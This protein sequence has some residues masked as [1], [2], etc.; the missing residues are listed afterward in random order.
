MTSSLDE[1][2]PLLYRA[3]WCDLSV[4]ARIFQRTSKP[5]ERLRS[6]GL[7]DS[8]G[9]SEYR[10][11]IRLA[12]GG[13][14]RVDL[15]DQDGDDYVAGCDGQV[16]WKIVGGVAERLSPIESAPIPFKNLLVPNWLV[17]RFAIDVIG[18]VEIGDRSAYSIHAK[19]RTGAYRHVGSGR[20]FTEVN[21][22][23]DAQ[24]GILLRCE[25]LDDRGARNVSELSDIQEGRSVEEAAEVFTF[26]VGIASPGTGI[27][28]P[29]S[30]AQPVQRKQLS[31]SVTAEE[32]N[33]IYRSHLFPA[34]FSAVLSEQSNPSL[35]IKAAR[36]VL[37]ASSATAFRIINSGWIQNFTKRIPGSSSRIAEVQISM[38]DRYRIDFRDQ[39]RGSIQSIVYD[40]HQTM[41]AYHGRSGFRTARS[42]PSG[43]GLIVDPAWLLDCY[44]LSGEGPETFSGRA[45]MRFI[46]VAENAAGEI[47]EGPLSDHDVPA[48]RIEVTIDRELG[49]TLRLAA[50]FQ[51]QSALT[52][53]LSEIVPHVPADA[54]RLEPPG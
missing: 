48:D 38:P 50:Y 13:R 18:T 45:A 2:I 10:G 17:A 21:G 7:R 47:L 43:M 49:I 32:L 15:T 20:D 28:S 29:A 51:G 52:C 41:K 14:Y 22:L 53:E 39:S 8:E 54:F 40:G 35:V 37:G 6:N 23:I 12:P 24:L 36:E 31:S 27:A 26:P 19:P 9:L 46:A 16:S 1:L 4:S 44:K 11:R 42:F 5:Q 30:S 3:R 33:L 34:E 25:T